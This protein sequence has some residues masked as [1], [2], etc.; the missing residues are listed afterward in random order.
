MV[1]IP[2]IPALGFQPFTIP[3]GDETVGL[4]DLSYSHLTIAMYSTLGISFRNF[5]CSLEL[6]L[7]H[8]WMEQFFCLPFHKKS[9]YFWIQFH[10]LHYTAKSL[11]SDEY[12]FSN[13]MIDLISTN[14]CPCWRLPLR[15]SIR[16]TSLIDLGLPNW[17]TF[18]TF[19]LC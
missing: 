14:L 8:N 16:L 13:F 10:K 9:F 2:K 7:W 18:I 4:K 6:S 3:Y 11:S 19:L 15:A 5:R 12:F 1:F 17:L